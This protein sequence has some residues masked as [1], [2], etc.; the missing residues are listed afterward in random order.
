MKQIIEALEFQVNHLNIIADNEG[1]T[2]ILTLR[3]EMAEDALII[4]KELAEPCVYKPH[5][6][7]GDI[8]SGCGLITRTYSNKY[9]PGC[10]REVKYED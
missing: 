7:A 5:K 3:L 6:L 4:A 2:N 1:L 8:I 9:C 10:G